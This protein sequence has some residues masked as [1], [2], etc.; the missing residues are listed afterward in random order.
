MDTDIG[1]VDI[2]DCINHFSIDEEIFC[3]SVIFAREYY[4]KY[5]N[6]NIPN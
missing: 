5:F 6:E 2:I 3:Q 1:Y 4:K